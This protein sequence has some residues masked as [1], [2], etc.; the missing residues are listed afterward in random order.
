MQDRHEHFVQR[1]AKHRRFIRWTAGIGGVIDGIFT[2]GNVG[3]GEHREVIHFVVIAGVVAV[4]PFGRQLALFNVT[5]QHNLCAGRYF[6]VIG[7]ALHHFGFGAAQQ[8][9]KGIF[10]QRIRNRRHRAQNGCRIGTQRDGNREAFARM[11][12]APLLEIQRPTAMGQPAHDELVLANQLLAI[13][14]EVLTLFM[15]PTRHGEAPG[16]QR[17]GIVRPALHDGNFGQIHRIAFQHFL[18]ARRTAQ[19]FGGH[20]QHLLK[21]RQLVEQVAEPFWRLRLFKK[22]QQFAH[23]T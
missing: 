16:D 1:H 11:G 4:R 14:A 13:N 12:R 23:F 17:C 6:Q 3:D 18:L 7:D 22:G 15:R 8:P 10:R 19:A 5:F 20:V 2:L 9:C 21:L